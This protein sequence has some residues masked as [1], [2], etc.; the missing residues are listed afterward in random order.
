MT[1][2]R[3]VTNWTA[4]RGKGDWQPLGTEDNEAAQTGSAPTLANLPTSALPDLAI[5]MPLLVQ[6]DAGVPTPRQ[7]ELIAAAGG[8]AAELL[9]THGGPDGDIGAL[10]RVTLAPGAEPQGAIDLLEQSAEVAFAEEDWTVGIQAISNDSAYT[11]GGLW[12]MYGDATGP[13]NAFGS[14]ASEAWAAGFTGSTNVVVGV[15][16]TGIDYR[17]AD[18][19]LNVWLNQRE[20]PT[21]LRALLADTD[22]DG[23]ITFRDLNGTAN[24]AFVS[25]LNANGRIDAG[26][27]LADTR[28]ENGLDEDR[29]GYRDD[30][31][32][33]DWV[34]NDN[35]P[36]DDH[37][38]GTHVAGTI[39]GMGGNGVGVAGVNWSVQMAGL[40]F[41]SKNGSGSV[42]NAIKA[43]DYFTALGAAGGPQDFVAT[44]NSWG[45]G[46]YSKAMQDAIARAANQGQL[47]IA[48][49]GN[50]GRDGIGDDNDLLGYYPTNYSTVATAGYEA[51]VA[52][53]ATTSSGELT[54]FSNYGDVTVDLGAPGQLITSTLT[55]GR[56]GAMS[57]TSMAAPH[58]TGAVALYA[59]ANPDATAAEIRAALL[60]SAAPTASLD[61]KTVTGGRLDVS[62]MLAPDVGAAPPTVAAIT[63][64]D[65]DLVSGETAR[66][67]I[68]FSKQVQG[69]DLADLWTDVAGRFG[70]LSSADGGRTWITAFAPDGGVLDATNRIGVLADGYT[71]VAGTVGG[72]GMSGNFTVDTV[73]GQV[74]YG[75]NGSDTLRG[76]AGD[77]TLSGVPLALIGMPGRG[78]IDTLIGGD[79]ADTFVLGTARQRFYDD[80]NSRNA[81][82]ADYAVI[83]DFVDGTDRV[84]LTKGTYFTAD[85]TVGGVSGAGIFFDNNAN[86]VLDSL[87][88]LFGLVANVS[89][90]S[91]TFTAGRDLVWAT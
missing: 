36:L 25:D 7:A 73:T 1:S 72:E 76:G 19:Y 87:D 46:S 21:T 79:G 13:I 90:A 69:F 88:E 84:Q 51:V 3:S 80:G 44:N 62:A 42:S 86:R 82:Y 16:D 2:F 28:W 18:L 48:A 22:L 66:V 32:G 10:L 9:R 71:D 30:L 61:G 23:L 68:T 67:V 43:V 5:H 29:N 50:G 65:T 27:L 20:I 91:I 45:G 40:K 63:L 83:A 37:N 31:V 24:A 41:L 6:F 74:I 8:Q 14:Q 89:A 39:G 85:V 77:D 78:T 75:T 47:F 26:D 54:R 55:N 70:A 58:V 12:G 35:D 34:N 52:V 15:I 59:A 81:G 57:G 64:S 4:A 38:H 56:Y 33:W 17:H 49:A 11:S 53:A 60:G